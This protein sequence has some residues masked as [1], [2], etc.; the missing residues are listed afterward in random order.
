MREQSAPVVMDAATLG[1]PMYEESYNMDPDQQLEAMIKEGHLDQ[2]LEMLEGWHDREPWNGEVLMRMAVVHWLAGQPARTLRDLDAYLEMDPDNAEALARRA[3]ALLMIGKRED[4]EA[5]LVRAEAIDP[6][7]PGVLLNRALL[8][9]EHG[10]FPRAIDTLTAYLEQMPQDHLALAR[11]SHLHRQLGNYG[12]A[13]TDALSCVMMHPEDP[14]AHFAEALAHVTMEQGEAA[15]ASCAQCLQLSESFLPALRLQIDLLADLGRL[16]EADTSFA[17]LQ[18][19]DPNAPQ[20]A[21]LHSRIA[22]E[23]GDFDGA[24]QW[25]SRYLDDCPDEAYGYYRRG[26]IY[27]RMDRYT[28][29][30]RDF[31]DYAGLAPHALEAYE[32]QYLCHLE[33][34]Q[35][36]E[37]AAV[38]KIARDLQPLNF[39]VQY[40]FAFA[41]LLCGRLDTALDGFDRAL[42]ADPASEE[43]LLRIQL[44]LAEYAP[45]ET[46]VHWFRNAAA[47]MT[48]PAP[49]LKGLLAEAY[50]E[51]GDGQ[52]ALSLALEILEED[53]TR[54]YGY[55]LGIKTLCL[56][57]RHAEALRLADAG[58]EH[59]PDDGRLWLAHA[60]VLRDIGRPEEALQQLAEAARLLPDDPEVLRQRALVYGSVGQITE[61]VDVLQTVMEIDGGSTETSFWLGY[62][63]LHLNRY[64]EALTAGDH[65]LELAAQSASG[66]LIRGAALRGLKR[67]QEAEKEFSYARQED[68]AFLTRLQEDPVI[69]AL[70]RPPS[71]RSR[72]SERLRRPFLFCWQLVCQAF[73]TFS[74]KAQ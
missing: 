60:L 49:M 14:E 40:N 1:G 29:A 34:G 52:Q 35:F 27:Y 36:Q 38:G 56:L 73:S 33:L 3:Q 13:L 12:Q 16:E 17:R 32:Q 37:A 72:L 19:A 57:N 59:L 22:T 48:A 55:L 26:M 28:D 6:A 20:T 4:A 31:Q 10:D 50:L 51:H 30:L 46:R 74:L 61:A 64:R 8:H 54:P 65:L 62:F 42:D 24:L 41:E 18:A 9:E 71:R 21:L 15:L 45:L 43:L 70:I 63:L 23:R 2:A 39:R 68:A 5:S 44:A 47:R 7:T 66:H 58:V 25:I 11:R 69:A 53:N 67:H